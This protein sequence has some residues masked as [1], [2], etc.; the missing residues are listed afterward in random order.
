M[1]IKFKNSPEK[2]WGI[3]EYNYIITKCL[4]PISN[5]LFF[6]INVPHSFNLLAKTLEFVTHF[7]NSVIQV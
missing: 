4:K 7:A 1:Y 5:A 3:F 2:I 6:I